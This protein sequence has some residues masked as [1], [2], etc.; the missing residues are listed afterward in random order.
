MKKFIMKLPRQYHEVWMGDGSLDFLPG[1]PP[2]KRAS[3][4]FIL[5]DSRLKSHAV[6]L[7]KALLLRG[8]RTHL[9]S[10]KVSEEL[11]D[12]KQIYPLFGELLKKNADR[13]SIILALGGGVIGDV[14]GFIAGTYMRGIRWVGIPSTLLAQVDS[15]LG[16]KTGMNHEQG[17]NLIGVIHQ[18]SLVLCDYQLLNSL[19]LRDQ[20]SGL[21]EMLKYGLIFDPKLFSRLKRQVK[22][23]G[24]DLKSLQNEISVCLKWKAKTVVRDE[25]DLKGIREVLNFGHT[26]GHALEA[27]SSYGTFR[28]G[29][30]LIYGMRVACELS[31]RR[32]Y[33]NQKTQSEIDVV[34]KRVQ[35]PPLPPK[36]TAKKYLKRIQSD[37]KA[38]N[39]RVR[40]VLLKKVGQ[41]VLDQECTD[42]EILDSILQIMKAGV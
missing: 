21:G 28:H 31:F 36:I 26:F 35:D 33:L 27:E 4:C 24:P 23:G 11:K 6:A 34:L 25:Q 18:P 15:A 40:F 1:F 32:G 12:F 10:L 2:L 8:I 29:E 20:I 30:A 22:P 16:G 14:V 5:T 3:Q 13:H 39:K 37:K 38:R 41:T 9:I 19:P 42:Q 7:E 17:K